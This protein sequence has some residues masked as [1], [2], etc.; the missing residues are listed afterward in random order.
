MTGRLC[1]IIKN[2][3]YLFIPYAAEGEAIFEPLSL[4][5]VTLADSYTRIKINIIIHAK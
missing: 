4:L 2:Y 5:H 1:Y 3:R